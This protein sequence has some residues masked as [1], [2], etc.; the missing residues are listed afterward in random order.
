MPSSMESFAVGNVDQLTPTV[1]LRKRRD[2]CALALRTHEQPQRAFDQFRHGQALPRGFALKFCHNRVVDV[3][4]RLH[5]A[6]HIT[7]RKWQIPSVCAYSPGSYPHPATGWPLFMH[8]TYAFTAAFSLPRRCPSVSMAKPAIR[9]A[10]PAFSFRPFHVGTAARSV[11]QCRAQMVRA[12]GTSPQT[13]RRTSRQRALETLL[14]DGRTPRGDAGSRRHAR[15][16]GEDSGPV[17]GR[18]A[19]AALSVAWRRSP[20]ILLDP[21]LSRYEKS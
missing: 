1:K 18:R 8:R 7:D 6:K 10:F 3:Q 2:F 4:R 11:R 14:L 20:R 19:G 9:R 13:Y 17:A 16:V 21:H 12:G 15:S 5:M